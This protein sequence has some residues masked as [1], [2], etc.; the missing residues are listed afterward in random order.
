MVAARKVGFLRPFAHVLAVGVMFFFPIFL[1]NLIA[2]Q[3]TYLGAGKRG[4]LGGQ[5]SAKNLMRKFKH[6]IS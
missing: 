4:D 1:P 2:R 3:R 6:E 5:P